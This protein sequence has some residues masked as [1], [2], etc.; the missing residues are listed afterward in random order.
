MGDF[1]LKALHAALDEQRRARGLTWAEATR[2]ISAARTMWPSRPVA[3]STITGLR[4][5]RLAEA[6]GVLQMLRWLGRA[7]ESFVESH[8]TEAIAAPLPDA[9]AGE[10]LRVDT[11]KLFAAP[12]W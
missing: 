1:D 3:S 5:K 12:G 4:T 8:A 11:R 2:E 7:P 9:A 10:V 6:D